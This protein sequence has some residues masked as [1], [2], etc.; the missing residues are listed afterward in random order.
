MSRKVVVP[1][2]K[3]PSHYIDLTT[4]NQVACVEKIKSKKTKKL[5]HV[6]QTLP[7]LLVVTLDDSE[8]RPAIC[9]T[10]LHAHR[11]CGSSRIL[12]GRIT[13]PAIGPPYKFGPETIEPSKESMLL[14][15]RGIEAGD[16]EIL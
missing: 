11:T 7:D 13:A 9:D 4:Q 1:K 16:P 6:N 14:V 15:L 12:R 10:V 3:M 5:Q 8:K 2:E